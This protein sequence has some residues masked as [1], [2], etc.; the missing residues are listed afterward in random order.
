MLSDIHNIQQQQQQ[1]QQ[2]EQQQNVNGNTQW[3]K[4]TV[5]RRRD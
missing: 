1:Q 3:R 4:G 2:N 5:K